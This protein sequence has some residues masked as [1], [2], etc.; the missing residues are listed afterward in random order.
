MPLIQ[1]T[2]KVIEAIL[3]CNAGDEAKAASIVGL[4]CEGSPEGGSFLERVA[5]VA[6]TGSHSGGLLVSPDSK[7]ITCK[8]LVSDA[9]E[10]PYSLTESITL[11]AANTL[12]AFAKLSEDNENISPED[13]EM[14]EDN[15][16]L[17]KDGEENIKDVVDEGLSAIKE[18]LIDIFS[19]TAK[20]NIRA[21]QMFASAIQNSDA[22]DLYCGLV[23]KAVT[24]AGILC[25]VDKI[26]EYK[27]TNAKNIAEAV[28]QYNVFNISRAPD[29]LLESTL[30]LQE[31]L[32]NFHTQYLR[33]TNGLI[34]LCESVDIPS[35]TNSLSEI[36][37][38]LNDVVD[39]IAKPLSESDI[40][41]GEVSSAF[42][43]ALV[44]IA[45][46]YDEYLQDLCSK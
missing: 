38:F 32:I 31:S 40:D 23:A 22:K 24:G 7:G 42:D 11:I 2:D 15:I 17:S 29:V 5:N 44:A 18:S 35:G 33:L 20:L 46:L 30:D 26:M 21:E 13:D 27:N 36:S 10:L 9:M 34:D 28:D 25:A 19:N 1:S 16:T 39:Q 45:A 12:S 8:D 37:D 43:K 14:S 4:Q 41:S 6:G 3:A